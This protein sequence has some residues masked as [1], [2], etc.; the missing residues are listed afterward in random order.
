[1]KNHKPLFFIT[2]F[3]VLVAVVPT[4]QLVVASSPPSSSSS[5][6]SSRNVGEWEILTKHNFSSQIQLYPHILLLL[7]IPWSGEARSLMKDVSLMVSDRFEEFGNL[8]LMY[9]HRNIEKMLA[10]SLG[11]SADGISVLYFHYSVSYK[12]RG[13]FN[14]RNIL[15]SLRPYMFLAP[16]EVPLKSLNTPEDLRVFVDSTDKVLVLV[17]FC[18][19][20]PKLLAKSRKNG[21]ENG[22]SMRGDHLGMGF[23]G[24]NDKLPVSSGKTNQKVPENHMCKAELG[25]NNGFCEAPGLGESASVNDGLLEDSKD[26]T[27]HVPY[28]CSPEQFEWFHSFYLKF[29]TA[30]REFFLPPERHKFGLVSDKSMLSSLG[31]DESGSW[32]AVLYQ[33]GCSSCSKIIKVEDDLNYV[34]QMNNYFVKELEGNGHDRDPILPANKPSVLLFVD[35]SSDSSETRGKSK[36]ALDAFRVLAQHYNVVNQAGNNSNDNHVK[37]S[38]QDYHEWKSKSEH[39]KLKLSMTAQKIKLKEK[40]SSIMLLKDGQQ[41]RLENIA[42]DIKASSLSEI[43]GYLL[44]QKKAS[45]LSSLAKD[46][47]FQLLSDD[48]D[49]KSANAEQPLSEF[50]SN[51][52][53][54]ETSQEGHTDTVE[55]ENAPH[56]SAIELQNNPNLNDPSSQHDEVKP[57]TIVS[58]NDIKYGDSEESVGDQDLSAANLKLETEDSSDGYTIGEGKSHFIGFNGS[59]FYSDGNYQLLKSLTGGSTIPSL[60]IVDPFWQ[61]HYVYPEEETFDF[62]S[63]HAFL[64][65]FLNGTLYPYQR[66]GHVLKGQREATRPPFVNLDFHELDSIPRITTCTFSELVIGFNLS[67]KENASNAWNKDVLV[68]FS[69]SWCAFCQRMEM[70]VREVY[71]AIKDYANMLKSGSQDVK[72]GLDYVTLKLPEIYLL[73]CTL[74]D[75]DLILKSA[76]QGEVYPAL[77]LFPAEIKKAILYQGDMAV[78]DIMKFVAD[79]GSNFHNL[80]K[81]KVLWVSERV[82]KNQDLYDTLQTEIHEE[83]LHKHSKY[84]AAPVHDNMVDEVVRPNVMNSPVSDGSH[85]ALSQVMTGSV[86]IA[87]EKLSGVQPFDRAKILIVAADQLTGF[88]GL[89]INK[90]IEW[91][92]LPTLQ[93]GFE[94]LKEAPLSFGGPVM[95]SGLPL[96]SLTTVSGGS[97]PE[98]L[99]GIY[100]LDQVTTIRR[101]EELKSA[102]KPADNYWFFLG[103]SSWGWD[104]L[105][106]EMAAGAWNL[107]DDGVRHL[108]WP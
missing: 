68:L 62:S 21:T 96:S 44:Q 103:F 18:G 31:V 41:L 102:N 86:L 77:I 25:I 85:E 69:N 14:A 88:Q 99:P 43:F 104:Q 64:S 39:P 84:V 47:G 94:K 49:I 57:P 10:D 105:Y 51:Q 38:I 98:I 53:S 30:V 22:F 91:N 42:S 16:E 34:L 97:S 37:V 54:T 108:N 89:I 56:R 45:K 29:M 12:Y 76:N 73:D 75:C 28:S 11:A 67:N 65:E 72:E 50:Q 61:Q 107:S 71:L 40:L 24:G 23:S 82:V 46:L 13:R 87:T 52:I 93:E 55:Q 26:T 63:V 90:P 60:V 27:F 59:F 33:A 81:E 20:T 5:S 3:T 35:R 1:M 32:F 36:E 100:F 83:S 70:V 7:T 15:S 74:N 6:S 58:S 66:S 19:W 8:K 80:I 2:I 95:Q 4:V 48:I 78:I 101:I 9:M 17:D 106:H 79:H 92:V